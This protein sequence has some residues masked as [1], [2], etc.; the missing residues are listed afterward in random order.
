MKTFCLGVCLVAASAAQTPIPLQV[1]PPQFPDPIETLR[2]VQEIRN[3]QAAWEIQRQE[4]EQLR[5]RNEKLREPQ[6]VPSVVPPPPIVPAPSTPGTQ[7]LSFPV[8]PAVVKSGGLYNGRMWKAL[9]ADYK[10][11]WLDVTANGVIYTAGIMNSTDKLSLLFPLTLTFGEVSQ[12]LDVFYATPENMPIPIVSALQIVNM[13]A[14]GVDPAV[15]EEQTN[16]FR[17]VGARLSVPVH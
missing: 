3:M 12:S 14:S 16:G 10:I 5:L 2:R 13:K 6:P 7:A 1:K 15:V 17:Q 9:T 4:A 8:D 11:L